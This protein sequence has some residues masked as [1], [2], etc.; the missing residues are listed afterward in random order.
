MVAERSGEPLGVATTR[1]PSNW[2]DVGIEAAGAA[3]K[4][5]VRS[6]LASAERQPGD[7]SASVFNLAGVD[8]PVDALLLGG[9]PEALG[10][11]GETQIANDAFAALRA[12]TPDPFGVVVAAGTGSIVAGRNP[13][14]E[15][16]RT[17]GL[18][19]LSGDSGSASEVSEA[20]V[21]AV[22][23]AYIGRGP[24]T[25]LSAMLCEATDSPSVVEFVEGTG[26]GRID[27]ARFSHLVVRAAAAGDAVARDILRRAGEGLGATAVHVLLSLGMEDLAFDLILAGGMF[28]SGDQDLI[29]GVSGVVRAAAPQAAIVL[30]DVPAVVGSV[31]LALELAGERPGSEAR[32]RLAE[33]MRAQAGAAF[34]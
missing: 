29:Q 4:S 27:P 17:L 28:R 34:G 32:T 23:L 20:G 19:P 12:G 21:T 7:L 31:L 24:T 26:R 14:G 8:F 6:A 3:I 10:I 33:G 15:E 11:G 22:A 9:I 18:G 30:L 2:E 13:A 16:F 1:D 5:C 25:A